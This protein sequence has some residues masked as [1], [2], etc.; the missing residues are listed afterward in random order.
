MRPSH[1]TSSS[2]WSLTWCR[3]RAALSYPTFAGWWA[4]D[5]QSFS[6]WSGGYASPWSDDQLRFVIHVRGSEGDPPSVTLSL[7]APTRARRR[8]NNN[9][10]VAT[11]TTSGLPDLHYGAFGQLTLK[12]TLEFESDARTTGPLSE[13]NPATDFETL[14]RLPISNLGGR[15]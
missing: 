11:I 1:L 12:H 7:C 5:L 8:I 15:N 6:Y 13:R 10:V 4:A 9:I 14:A 2:P 3:F